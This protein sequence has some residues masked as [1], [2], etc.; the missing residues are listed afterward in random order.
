MIKKMNNV[1][2]VEAIKQLKKWD[3]KVKADS[4][5]ATIY[6][7]FRFQLAFVL[8]EE[9]LGK[10]LTL[11]VIGTGY[12]KVLNHGSGYTNNDINITLGLLDNPNSFFINKAGGKKKVLYTAME[13][14]IQ[15][16][17]QKLGNNSKDWKWGAIHKI[18][19]NH[20]LGERVSAFSRGPFPFD[21]D[22]DTPSQSN[23]YP[24]NPYNAVL[25]TPSFRM[26]IDLSNLSNSQAILPTGNCGH[27]GNPHY[28]DCIQEYIKGTLRPMLWTE[29]DIK[30]N[31]EAVLILQANINNSRCN[32]CN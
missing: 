7:V 18:I 25:S 24:D 19:F 30:K 31:V 2:V 3:C 22:K 17:K 27:L 14:A 4:V 9:P 16:L 10:D 8:L 5:E 20:K 12:D 1:E 29:E 28:D 15:Y 32:I 21:G 13:K 26:I 11:R 23:W 6:E